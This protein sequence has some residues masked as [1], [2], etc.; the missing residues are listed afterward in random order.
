MNDHPLEAV[1]L[2][3]AVL[4]SRENY[5]NTHAQANAILDTLDHLILYRSRGSEQRYSMDGKEMRRFVSEWEMA[6]RGK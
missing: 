3:E 5:P 2:V 6:P 4:L 1:E